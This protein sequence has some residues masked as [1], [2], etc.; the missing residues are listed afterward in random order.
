MTKL[1]KRIAATAMAAT[2]AA[3]AVSVTTITA[4]AKTQTTYDFTVWANGKDVKANAK[5]NI[6]EALYKTATLEHEGMF[7]G[8]KWAVMVTDDTIAEAEDLVDCFTDKGALT[9]DAKQMQK[10]MKNVAS[11]KIKDGKITVTAGKEAGE[12]FVWVYEIKNKAVVNTETVTPTCYKG[13]TKMAPGSLNVTDE[14]DN[15]DAAVKTKYANKTVTVDEATTLYICDTKAEIDPNAT[16][17][18]TCDTE[19]VEIGTVSKKPHAFTITAS[20]PV[21][22]FKV[23]ITC[24]ESGKKMSL[25]L[26]AVAAVE[27]DDE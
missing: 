25:T 6:E 13:I 23:T 9:T 19:S 14:E 10:D 22:K 20:E 5:K 4:A 8:G 3:T 12:F 26:S 16:I 21:K 18:V 1:F 24:A 17:T 11:A 15:M 7:S 2:M 27:E